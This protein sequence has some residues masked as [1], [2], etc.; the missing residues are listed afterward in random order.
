MQ[1]N[2][3][4]NTVFLAGPG[5]W[6]DNDIAIYPTARLGDFGIAIYTAPG[7]TA[8]PRKYKGDGTPGYKALVSIHYHLFRLA[9][10]LA[11]ASVDS[12]TNS[13]PRN[14]KT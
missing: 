9:C 3:D 12:T 6:N 13:L 7:D 5:T 1:S 4:L 2:I 10:L 11:S 14:K 8:N